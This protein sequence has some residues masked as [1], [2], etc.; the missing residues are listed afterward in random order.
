MKEILEATLS[1]DKATNYP[2]LQSGTIYLVESITVVSVSVAVRVVA[3]FIKIAT[4][5]VGTNI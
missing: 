3:L 5:I 4:T 1:E 2:F